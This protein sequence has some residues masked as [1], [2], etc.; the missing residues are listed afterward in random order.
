MLS[1]SMVFLALLKTTLFVV[2][3]DIE[4]IEKWEGEKGKYKKKRAT[5]DVGEGE[6]DYSTCAQKV[7]AWVM[8]EGARKCP[9]DRTEF[10]G[11]ASR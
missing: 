8:V 3:S 4:W 1:V 11:A 2:F 9:L 7:R 6:G 5:K 10:R